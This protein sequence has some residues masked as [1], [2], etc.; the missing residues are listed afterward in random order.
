MGIN[1][2]DYAQVSGLTFS[3]GDETTAYR[4]LGESRSTIINPVLASTAGVGVGD[5]IE[6]LTP[7]GRLPYR[8]IAIGGDYL[9]SKITT[10]YISHENIGA[11]FGRQ[12][13]VLLQLNVDP[14]ADRQTVE[15]AI[16]TAVKAYPQFRLIDGQEYIAESMRM[17][18][19]AFA[20]L[21]ALV[22]FLAIPSLIAMVN[23]LA[24]GV[25][26]RTR[27]IGMLRAVGATRRQVR[28]IIVIEA[29]ILAAI[30]TGFGV[31]SGLYLGYMGVEA[32]RQAGFPMEYAFPAAGVLTALAAGILFGVLAAIVPARQAARLQV[33][34]ALRYE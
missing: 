26:E 20:G 18:D 5:D 23:T 2:P 7:A 6:L 29:I 12:E 11:D 15:D 32:L 14:Q 27:E 25:I 13:D 19:A 16:K 30:G 34:Q 24:I 3:E 1:P 21:Y 4:A 31:L 10:A 17:F 28:T 9:N 33:V 8:V 22:I